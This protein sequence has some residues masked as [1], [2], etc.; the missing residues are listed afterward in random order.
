MTNHTHRTDRRPPA[1]QVWPGARGGNGRALPPGREEQRGVSTTG[2]DRPN[3]LQELRRTLRSPRFWV[4]LVIV[5]AINWF[6]VPLLFPQ[7]QDH[8]TVPYTFFKQQVVAGNVTEITSRGEDIQGTFKQMVTDPKAAVQTPTTQSGGVQAPQTYTKFATIKPA[9]DDPELL[10]LL[11][12]N[13]VVI[14]ASPLEQTRSPFLTVLLLFGPT[15]LLIGGFLWLSSRA[16]RAASGGLLGIG[17]SRARRYEVTQ[18]AERMTFED[19]AGI[20]EVERDLVEIVDFLKQPDK[21]QRLGGRIPKGVLLVGAPGTGK[22]LLARAVAGE[23]AVPFF[24]MSGSE[25]IEMIVGVGAARVRD[26]FVEARK[27]APAIIFVDE[28]DAIG[29]RR[30]AG[31]VL[32]GNDEREQTLNQLLIEMDGFSS[33]EAVIV[34]AAT[35][36][37]DVLDPALLRPGRFDRRVIVQPPDRAGRAAI[38]TV[39]TRGVPLAPGT[40]LNA[41][42]A[43]TPGLVG[44][45]LR[46]LV[47]EAALLAAREGK[48]AVDA[49]DFAEALEKIAL[50]AERR[51]TLQ[52]EERERIAYHES[53][54]ALLGLLQP[55]GDPVRRVTVVP[56]GRALGATVSVPEDDRYNY[57]EPYLRARIVSALG[58]RAAEQLIYRTVTTGAENDIKQVTELARAMVTRWG[59]SLEVG[60]LALSGSDEGNFLEIGLAGGAMRPYS[61]Q[62]AQVIDRAIRQIVDECYT[63]AVDMLTRERARLEALAAVL[64]REESLNEAQMRIAAGLESRPAF[65]A[66][67]A[68]NHLEAGTVGEIAG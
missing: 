65:E 12:Q 66:V 34:L 40:D 25:F 45:D 31:N 56:R 50:G 60:L 1:G 18:V 68:V 22:T 39:H 17:R 47:N 11:E 15:L 46:N 54:H 19:V 42:G 44:A 20:D 24:S 32:G 23:A 30:G 6:L 41:L 27:A 48:A 16:A 36:R 14:T 9:F 8:V 28:L 55:E 2:G 7:P 33:R 53:G 35:N 10:L 29:R 21:Y 52:P 5:L 38:L 26:L 37:A 57:S 49:A 67:L 43:E 3:D 51:L 4:T 64:L 61:E 13:K 59:M 58:G 63:K 62:T